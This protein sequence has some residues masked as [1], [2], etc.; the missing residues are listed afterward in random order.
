MT[1]HFDDLAYAGRSQ[2]FSKDPSWDGSGNRATYQARDVGGAH[3]FGFSD[4]SHA[5]GR[6]GEI[7]GTFWRSDHWGYYADRVGPLS[8][9]DRLEARGRVVLAVGAPDADMCFGWFRGGRGGPAPNKA[10][11][12]IGVKVG[13]PT[14]VG[15]Y[16]L[17]TFTVNE[18]VRGLPNTGPVL[19]PG[20]SYEWSLVYDPAANDGSGAITASLGGESVTHHLRPGQKARAG[21]AKLDR[22]GLFSIGPGGQIVKLYLDDLHYTAAPAARR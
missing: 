13:G 8:F 12:F 3:D 11:D 9:E 20:K 21:D 19:R 18:Q 1:I 17:P 7:G 2:D 4:T 22:F 16:F 5:G 10:G 6:R 15:H 14:R